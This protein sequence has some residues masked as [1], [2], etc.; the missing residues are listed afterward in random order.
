MNLFAT[1]NGVIDDELNFTF[2]PEPY[3]GGFTLNSSIGTLRINRGSRAN[4]NGIF[5]ALDGYSGIIQSPNSIEYI[6]DWWNYNNFNIFIE[7]NGYLY[8]VFEKVIRNIENEITYTGADL[9]RILINDSGLNLESEEFITIH[10]IPFYGEFYH[11][12]KANHNLSKLYLNYKIDPFNLEDKNIVI[13]DLNSL[14]VIS[15]NPTSYEIDFIYNNK[16]YSIQRNVNTNIIEI[17]ESLDGISW[18]LTPIYSMPADVNNATIDVYVKHII[19]NGILYV[20]YKHEYINSY[21]FAC[22]ILKFDG[23]T[24]TIDFLFNNFDET[25]ILFNVI[26]FAENNGTFIS[27][28]M[29]FY[30]GFRFNTFY[31][32]TDNCNTWDFK[33]LSSEAALSTISKIVPYHRKFWTDFKDTA[34]YL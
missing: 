11:Y 10:S 6:T 17:R 24:W 16:C 13:I 4:Y 27:S 3:R 1:P 21:R 32:S 7:I 31:Y 19:V 14:T 26:D 28:V 33:I 23:I 22:K 18:N 30:N 5:F 34:E 8:F 20:L 29:T 25:D 2:I 15:D 9:H 12:N